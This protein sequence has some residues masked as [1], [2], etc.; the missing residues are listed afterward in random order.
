M[1]PE[2]KPGRLTE[3]AVFGPYLARV[4]IEENPQVLGP[5]RPISEMEVHGNRYTRPDGELAH[6]RPGEAHFGTP[7][8]IAG[9]SRRWAHW[10]SDPS[11]HPR[12]Q[13]RHDDDPCGR[14]AAGE[15]EKNGDLPLPPVSPA[16]LRVQ[17]ARGGTSPRPSTFHASVAGHST[18][19][20]V[21]APSC[22]SLGGPAPRMCAAAHTVPLRGGT[23]RAG[24]RGCRPRPR[25]GRG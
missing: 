11:E 4:A 15:R 19:L 24:T 17:M 3:I 8:W 20:D 23:R 13:D 7:V 2:P 14:K 9:R 25:W 1:T 22:R 6:R 12:A 10:A 21:V 18:L 5:A 16:G